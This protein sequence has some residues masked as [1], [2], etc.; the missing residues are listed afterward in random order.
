MASE[1][2]IETSIYQAIIAAVSRRPLQSLTHRFK[3]ICTQWNKVEKVHCEWSSKRT[4]AKGRKGEPKDLDLR[5]SIDYRYKALGFSGTTFASSMDQKCASNFSFRT[6]G[7][8]RISQSDT[9]KKK[10]TPPTIPKAVYCPQLS[11]T[12]AYPEIHFVH[13]ILF[14]LIAITVCMNYATFT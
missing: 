5:W 8:A 13:K 2:E 3:L 4:K 11:S 14:F 7:S 10:I 6:I 1:C 12:N 9:Y